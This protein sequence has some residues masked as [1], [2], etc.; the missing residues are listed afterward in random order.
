MNVQY[1]IL[2]I[3]EIDWPPYHIFQQFE[4]Y[5]IALKK[6]RKNA[7]LSLGY[8]A[9]PSLGHTAIPISRYPKNT[10]GSTTYLLTHEKVMHNLIK[11]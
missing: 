7:I 1:L 2:G 11:T 8:T 10:L 6:P 5:S 3:P 4:E 9:I